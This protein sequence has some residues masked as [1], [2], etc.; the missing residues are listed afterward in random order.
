M[1]STPEELNEKLLKEI[2]FP[3]CLVIE[4][5]TE[6]IAHYTLSD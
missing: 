2:K 3:T 6:K 1:L 4:W 5:G